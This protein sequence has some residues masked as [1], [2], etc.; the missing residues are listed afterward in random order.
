MA[1]GLLH[2]VQARKLFPEAVE[3]PMIDAIFN[4]TSRLLEKSMSLRMMRQGILASNIANAE[5]PNYRSIDI[6]FS[7][8]MEKL[9]AAVEKKSGGMELLQTDPRHLTRDGVSLAQKIQDKERIVWKASDS[10]SIG[11][12]NNSVDAEVELTKA[13]ENAL[14]YSTT[15][16][17]L[18]KKMKG[19]TGI[20]DSV[21]RF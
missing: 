16:Q 1:S 14:M 17:L 2:A 21:S 15:T 6:D 18:A 11:N 10:P 12:D 8:T 9:V 3:L 4:S 19:L 20:L 13:Q 7:G 5:T